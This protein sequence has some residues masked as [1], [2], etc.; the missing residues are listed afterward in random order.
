MLAMAIS[1]DNF[2]GQQRSVAQGLESIAHAIGDLAEAIREG[3]TN[4]E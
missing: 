1:G 4:A 3:H 2:L